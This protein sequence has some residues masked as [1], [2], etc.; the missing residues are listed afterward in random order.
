VLEPGEQVLHAL[1]EAVDHERRS[2]VGL[3]A[4]HDAGPL[5]ALIAPVPESVSRSIST[6]SARTRKRLNEASRRMLS[7]S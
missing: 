1:E 6:S 7:R 5:L 4:A 3:V 2:G